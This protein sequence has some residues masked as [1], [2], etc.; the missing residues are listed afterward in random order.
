[1]IAITREHVKEYRD[2]LK[3]DDLSRVTVKNRVGG[4]GT[5]VRHGITKDLIAATQNPFD[6]IDFDDVPERPAIEDRRPYRLEELSVLFSS[7]VYTQGPQTEGQAK[8]SSC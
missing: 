2:H 6:N 8:E 5:L 3:D 4:L 1:M 7:P